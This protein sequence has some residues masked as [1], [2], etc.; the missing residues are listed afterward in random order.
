MKYKMR[1]KQYNIESNIIFLHTVKYT[2]KQ[3][4]QEMKDMAIVL[5]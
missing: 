5:K 3:K 1:I 2:K 4:S